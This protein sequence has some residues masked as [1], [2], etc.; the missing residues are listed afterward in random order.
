MSE[1]PFRPVSTPRLACIVLDIFAQI[2]PRLPIHGTDIF[3]RAFE[4]G[5]KR[6]KEC[7]M[8]EIG[9]PERRRVLVP[10]EEPA[11]PRVPSEPSR[12]PNLPPVRHPEREP[13]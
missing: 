11:S 2:G 1:D 3:L 12:P 7:M 13:A 6:T 9:E 10:D 5:A 8:A 4:I